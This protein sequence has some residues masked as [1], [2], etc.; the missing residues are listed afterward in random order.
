[1]KKHHRELTRRLEAEGVVG[2]TLGRQNAVC[3]FR[4]AA[5]QVRQYFTGQSPS[6]HRAAMKATR[7][8]VRMARSTP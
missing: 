2:W 6:D 7:D 5:G 1:M 8:I 4:D 3:H